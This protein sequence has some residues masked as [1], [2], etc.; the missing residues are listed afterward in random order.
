MDVYQPAT[1]ILLLWC[2]G[3]LCVALVL[4][5]MGMVKWTSIKC[6]SN[7]PNAWVV[8]WYLM[9]FSYFVAFV[10]QNEYNSFLLA[11]PM[12]Q[13]SIGLAFYTCELGQRITNAFSILDETLG[14]LDW[15]EH[16]DKLIGYFFNFHFSWMF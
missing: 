16:I 6:I 2:V 9:L 8:K 5:E 3:T 15:W 12:L 10:R 1:A 11:L 7:C 14:E 13:M 4:L